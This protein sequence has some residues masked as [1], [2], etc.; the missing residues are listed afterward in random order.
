M[1]C[2]L[3]L[4]YTTFHNNTGGVGGG[5]GGY[6]R[7]YGGYGGGYGRYGGGYG[8]GYGGLGPGYVLFKSYVLFKFHE[9]K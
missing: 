4:L 3:P 1:L 2:R 6:G 7:G 9:V 8:G 5:Y